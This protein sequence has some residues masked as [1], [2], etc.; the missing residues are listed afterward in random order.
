MKHLINWFHD[1]ALYKKI[2]YMVIIAGIIPISI[3][4]VIFAFRLK[5][6]SVYLQMYMLDKGYDQTYQS[7]DAFLLRMYNTAT[8]AAVNEPIRSA[9]KSKDFN[10]SVVEELMQFEGVSSFTYTLELN[11]DEV[12]ILYYID[13]SFLV[14]NSHNS[15]YRTIPYMK[16]QNWYETLTDRNGIP[17]W[18]VMDERSRYGKAATYFGTVRTLWDDN[19][20]TNSLGAVA[21]LTDVDTIERMLITSLE[22]QVFYLETADGKVIGTN[23]NYKKYESL[24]E[25]FNIISST[26]FQE[27]GFNGIQYFVRKMAVD[28]TNLYFTSIVPKSS[29]YSDTF[30]A[31]REMI[32]LYLLVCLLLFVLTVFISK[33]ITGRI[34][35]LD[36]NMKEDGKLLKLEVEPHKDEIGRLITRYNN[37]VIRVEDLLEE[38]FMMG[39]EKMGAELK[40]LQSQINPHFLYNTLDM[41][42][43]MARKNETGNIQAALQAMSAFYR[44]A[45]SKGSDIIRIEDELHMCE[46][47]IKIQSMRF[48]GKIQFEF[49]VQPDI[50]EYLIPKITLQPF[51][52]NSIIHGIN[53]KTDGRGVIV[54]NGWLEDDRIILSVTDDGTGMEKDNKNLNNPKGS[55]YGMGNIEKRLNL[56]YGEEIKLQI[57]SSMGIGTCVSINIP[58][59]KGGDNNG[60]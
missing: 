29:L 57:D 16:E 8:L 14:A 40:A 4:T 10:L 5:S 28:N 47:Y 6:S 22:E 18:V 3:L 36:K 9:L 54:L 42:N 41:L 20:Y 11:M 39:Q 51:I 43:W 35:L 45:L 49:D 46:A 33:P 32:L 38:Q 53:E 25:D 31:T 21:V 58:M 13:D 15:R 27:A 55:R 19:D 56:F 17:T 44:M 26:K 24:F 34:K 60:G 37:M 59:R 23:E 7:I 50:M 48:K 52:E 2:T 12:N 30:T 1:L